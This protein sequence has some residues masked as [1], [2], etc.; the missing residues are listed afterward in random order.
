MN[1]NLNPG[2]TTQI[3]MTFNPIGYSGQTVKSIYIK[4]KNQTDE[5]RLILTSDVNNQK[6]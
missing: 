2:E 4:V 3:K 6:K 1:Y 5:L